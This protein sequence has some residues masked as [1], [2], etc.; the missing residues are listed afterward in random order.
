MRSLFRPGRPASATHHAA[1]ALARVLA[2]PPLRAAALVWASAMLFVIFTFAPALGNIAMPPWD[3]LAHAGYFGGVAALLL[4]G[5]TAERAMLAFL[6]TSLAGMADEIHQMSVPGRQADVMDWLTDTAAAAL[7]IL[8]MR[9]L[10][11]R[12]F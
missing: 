4:I 9:Y 12:R 6:L 11:K 10:A 2:L 1:P 3:K 8:M 5:L 7:A